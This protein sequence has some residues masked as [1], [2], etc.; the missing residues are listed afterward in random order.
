MSKYYTIYINRAFLLPNHVNE[1]FVNIVWYFTDK[2]PINIGLKKKKK[3]TQHNVASKTVR[4]KS[5]CCARWSGWTRS[6]HSPTLSPPAWPN[7]DSQ[8]SSLHYI[9]QFATIEQLNHFFPRNRTLIT[10]ALGQT[11]TKRRKSIESTSN[12]MAKQNFTKTMSLCL[13][14]FKARTPPPPPPRRARQ[15]SPGSVRLPVRCAERP[16]A[17]RSPL[18]G[19]SA[20]NVE[21]CPST[22]AP[23]AGNGSSSAAAISATCSPST[24]S[25]PGSTAA[26]DA[27]PTS[28]E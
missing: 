17:G 16:T 22:H 8:S 4:A 24:S 7:S 1:I 20:R 2:N 26:V 9:P 14:C 19:T 27:S 12:H 21:N 10:V 18:P 28:S 15:P 25:K 23:T 11:Q 5:H 13:F 6:F 3:K